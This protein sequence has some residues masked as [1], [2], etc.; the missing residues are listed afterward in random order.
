MIACC[1]WG[2]PLSRIFDHA[3]RSAL[4]QSMACLRQ[5]ALFSSSSGGSSLPWPEPANAA[6]QAAL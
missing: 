2:G 4:S 3:A 5:W 6:A 1:A